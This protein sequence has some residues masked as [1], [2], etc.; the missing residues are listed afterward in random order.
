VAQYSIEEKKSFSI[1]AGIKKSMQAAKTHKILH[2]YGKMD[3]IN[4]T[5]EK[6]NTGLV[7]QEQA[8]SF[9]CF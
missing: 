4:P 3:T 5:F 6:A 7:E 8:Q 1:R 9:N 2:T